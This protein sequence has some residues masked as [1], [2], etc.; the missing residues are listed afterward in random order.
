MLSD[1]DPMTNH[2]R[3]YME[4]LEKG[5]VSKKELL[6]LTVIA[7]VEKELDMRLNKAV[8]SERYNEELHELRRKELLLKIKEQEI[9]LLVA[10]E[11]LKQEKIKTDILK[12]NTE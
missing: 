2:Q 1:A 4:I 8:K 7:A 3:K 5:H 12:R 11:K 10:Q 6:M 9:N